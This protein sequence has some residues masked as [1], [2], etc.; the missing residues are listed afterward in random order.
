MHKKKNFLIKKNGLDAL[1]KD[2]SKGQV[3][4]NKAKNELEQL[5]TTDPLPLQRAKINQS[6]TVRKSERAHAEAE[7]TRSLAEKARLEASKRADSAK[8]ARKQQEK[9]AAEAAL[10]VEATAVAREDAQAKLKQAED[11]LEALKKIP[12]QSYGDIWWMEREIA[13]RKRYLPQSKQ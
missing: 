8:T 1:S 7:S 4:R 5:K 12:D 6:A 11:A 3:A 13:E 2:E 10:A 9:S